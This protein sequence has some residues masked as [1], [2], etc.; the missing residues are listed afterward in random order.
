MLRESIYLLNLFYF[1]FTLFQQ[2]QT[3]EMKYNK[4]DV[5]RSIYSH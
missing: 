2:V 1:M 5:K 3:S 4:M